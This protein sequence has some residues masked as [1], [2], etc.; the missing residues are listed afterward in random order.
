V[1]VSDATFITRVVLKNYKSIASCDVTL[2]PLT[3]LVGPNGS[4]KSN[5]VDALRF[6]SDALSTSLDHAI[7]TRGGFNEIRRRS[8]SHSTHFGI[9]IEFRLGEHASGHYAF[10][11]G[12]PKGDEFQVTEEECKIDGRIDGQEELSP[13]FGPPAERRSLRVQGRLV[14]VDGQAVAPAPGD[15]LFLPIAP[16]PEFWYLDRLLSEMSFY[17]VQPERIRSH[18]GSGADSTLMPDGLNA[19]GILKRLIRDHPDIAERLDAYL[20]LIVPGLHGVSLR[21][22]GDDEILEFH[23]VPPG[24]KRSRRFPASSVSDGTLRALGILLALFQT[25][26]NEHLLT[27][28]LIGIEEPVTGLHPAG[29]EVVFEALREGSRRRQV[30]VTSHSADLLDNKDVDTNSILAVVA[31]EGGTHIGPIEEVGRSALRDRLFTVGELL[32]M[33]QLRPTTGKG[34]AARQA[35]LFSDGAA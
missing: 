17:S 24:A 2:G 14:T 7:Q 19:S 25:Q 23:Q 20:G 1:T 11:I 32:R 13:L 9:R 3:F 6:V 29:A 30:V 35:Q 12:A 5:F 15:R 10:L 27:P 4:G 21:S 22:A 33:D 8:A 31:D 28:P 18:A 34:K 16:R 26:P